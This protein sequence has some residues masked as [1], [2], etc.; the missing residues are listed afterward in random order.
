MSKANI[1]LF[2]FIFISLLIFSKNENEEKKLYPSILTLLSQKLVLILNDG[3]HFYDST[4]TNEETDKY[5]ALNIPSKEDNYKTAMAQFSSENDGYILILV[6]NKIYFFKPDGT[7]ITSDDISGLIDGEFYCITPYKKENNN[8][9]YIISYKDGINKKLILH[10]FIFNIQSHINERKNFKNY[11]VKIYQTDTLPADIFGTTCLLLYSNTIGYN[12]L[13]CIYGLGN[14]FEIHIRAFDPKNNYD[15]LTGNFHHYDADTTSFSTVPPFISGITN[16]N[17]DK[18]LIYFV[19]QQFPFWMTFDFDNGFSSFIDNNDFAGLVGDYPFNKLYYF[20]QTHEIVIL[21]EINSCQVYLFAFK[22]DFQLKYKSS[23]HPTG[24]VDNNFFTVFYNGN[25]YVIIND[26]TNESDNNLFNTPVASFE[27]FEESVSVEHPIEI[28]ITDEITENYSNNK[29]CKTSTIESAN[30]DLCI[31]CNTDEHYFPAEIKNQSLFHGFTECFNEKTKP[32]NFYFNSTVNKYKICYET[33]LT[34]DGDGDDINNNCLLCDNDHI[35]KPDYPNSKNCVTKCLY[36]YYYTPYGYYKCSNSSNCPEESNLYIKELKKCTNDCNREEKY[37]YQYGGFCLEKCPDNTKANSEKVCMEENVEHCSKNEN[38]IDLYEFL[39]SGGVD[40]NAKNYAKEFHYTDKHLSYYYNSQYSILIYKDSNCIEELNI[41]M[42]KVDFQSCYIKVQESLKPINDKV[43]ISLVEKLNGNQKSKISYFFYHPKTGEKLDADIIC[44]DE[45]VVIKESVMNQLNNSNVNL[46][47]AL[48]LTEQNINIFDQSDAFYTDICYHFESPNGKDIPVK[49]RI[50]IYYPN[51]T[52]CDAGCTNKGVNLTTMESIC[53]CKFNNILSNDLIEGNALIE[54]SLGQITDIISNSNLDVLKCYKDVFVKEYIIKGIGGFIIIL[55]FLAQLVF[56]FIFF[57]IDMG[58]IRKYLYNIM[59]SFIKSINKNN[60]NNKS[61]QNNN[62]I[63]MKEPPK[64]MKKKTRKSSINEKKEEK[65]SKSTI[66]GKT[67]N[68]LTNRKLAYNNTPNLLKNKNLKTNVSKNSYVLAKQETNTN[69]NNNIDMEEYL[70][71]DYDDMEYDDAIK[72]DKR[73]FC[74]FFNDRLKSK[75]MIVDTFYNKDNIRPMSIKI[76]LFLLNIDLYFVING[77][78]FS[79][80]YIIEL[81]HLETED[82]FFSY[83]PRS[84]GRFFY[85]T[86]VSVIVGIIIDCIFLEEKKIKR[87]LIREKEDL[88]QLKYEVAI[89]SNSLKKR[90]IIFIIV[91][92]VIS[93]V[94]WYYVCCF[95]NVYKG[96]KGE[97]IKSSITIIIIMQILSILM[98]LLEAIIRQIS[99]ECKSEKIYKFRQ[100]LS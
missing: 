76:I 28:H 85:A 63:K 25:Y 1:Y 92:F 60:K 11:E 71:T 29:K 31:S 56:V 96:V 14:P 62:M 24:C 89:T 49:E 4:L 83:I 37:K 44:K 84:I 19:Y 50:K 58:K 72:N 9:N 6:M 35:K 5:I 39:T 17:N 43:I 23:F 47:S 82:S 16:L 22:N 32:T 48:F 86:M 18:I 57:I 87:I 93:L 7:Y 77:L 61:F 65:N 79:E 69:N 34:C 3:I 99:F 53:E 36:S 67:E 54:G 80:E 91:C 40:F 81:Y 20:R 74:E 41:K 100:L 38:E 70:K 27:S 64:K 97:W 21:S 2:I 78:F 33:C 8:L 51:I 90:Y 98:T 88:L 73:S 66:S 10:H 13:T 59:E 42:P 52:L 15:E 45:E 94:S 46:V 55:I 75:Q 26:S 95:N 30:Y 12:I 68:F